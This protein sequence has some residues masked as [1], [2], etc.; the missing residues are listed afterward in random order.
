VNIREILFRFL[1]PAPEGDS[2]RTYSP[3]GRFSSFVVPFAGVSA[4]SVAAAPRRER[5]IWTVLGFNFMLVP[6]CSSF[7]FTYVISLQAGV[8]MLEAMVA[9]PFLL[10]VLAVF[11][12]VIATSIRRNL[13]GLAVAMIVIRLSM[14]GFL[15]YMIAEPVMVAVKETA[16]AQQL[17]VDEQNKDNKAIDAAKNGRNRILARR[18]HKADAITYWKYR[19]PCSAGTVECVSLHKIRLREAQSAYNL[20]LKNDSATLASLKRRI[21]EMIAHRDTM[22]ANNGAK[23]L[24]ASDL[25]ARENA[26]GELMKQ[27]AWTLVFVWGLR[28][29]WLLFEI[30]P[31]TAKL[32][33]VRHGTV[34]E[35]H[36]DADEKEALLGEQHRHMKADAQEMLRVSTA[37]RLPEIIERL[38]DIKVEELF[39]NARDDLRE[40]PHLHSVP[41]PEKE[42]SRPEKPAGRSQT[43]QKPADDREEEPD[44]YRV[45]QLTFM[46]DAEREARREAEDRITTMMAVSSLGSIPGG[47]YVIGEPLGSGAQSNVMRAFDRTLKIHVAI[48]IAVKEPDMLRDEAELLDRLDHPNIIRKLDMFEFEDGTPALVLER[49]GDDLRRVLERRRVAGQRFSVP[50]LRMF[51][52]PTLGALDYLHQQGIVHGDLAPA[53]HLGFGSGISS[54]QRVIDLHVAAMLQKGLPGLIVGT[55]SYV[56]PQ[57]LNGSQVTS[58]DDIYSFGV[59]AYEALSATRLFASEGGQF[60]RENPPTAADFGRL[61]DDISIATAL[62][63]T[64]SYNPADRPSAKD[65]LAAF[66]GRMWQTPDGSDPSDPFGVRDEVAARRN[67]PTVT[68]SYSD[69]YPGKAAPA[70]ERTT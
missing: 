51:G 43:S 15:G 40:E 23:L 66:Q 69:G 2:P 29:L 62:E 63:K 20:E 70:K 10:V 36:D 50:E 44:D 54:D 67:I 56:S 4:L 30:V 38:L 64:L 34:V 35:A 7:A 6:L 16:I 33:I 48:K 31:I 60:T 68:S 8:S 17:I 26:L 25:N 42:D 57:Q 46:L 61:C 1:G 27:S 45:K 21:P 9:W 13:T 55:K 58:A 59:I 49:C 47:R 53:N 37:K 14:A 12:L 41:D 32:V 18:R 3:L 39:E 11:E 28:I 52:L 19:A 24:A 22:V 65:L 5:F